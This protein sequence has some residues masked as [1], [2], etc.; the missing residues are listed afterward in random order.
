M[1]H[2][3]ADKLEDIVRVV[4]PRLRAASSE[5][6]SVPLRPGGWSTKEVVG[7]LID[8]ASNNHQRFVRMQQL[9]HIRLAGYD[10][11]HWVRWQAYVDADWPIL[12]TLWASYNR[13]LAHVIRQI[14][15]KTLANRCEIAPGREL[16][17]DYLVDDYLGHLEHHLRQIGVYEATTVPYPLPPKPQ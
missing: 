14:P 4:E 16:T 3:I 12:V 8:S 17:L 9:A 5:Q 1:K 2:K 10:Q 11:E 6:A 15:P 13:H 7:H